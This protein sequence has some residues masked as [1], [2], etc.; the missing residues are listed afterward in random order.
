MRFFYVDNIIEDMIYKT[1]RELNRCWCGW[2]GM[3]DAL[4][5]NKTTL[6]EWEDLHDNNI[7][8]KTHGFL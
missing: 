2:F 1:C 7:Q 6:N 5:K 4:L 3:G 8:T